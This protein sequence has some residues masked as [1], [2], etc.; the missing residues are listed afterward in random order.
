MTS[1][2][3]YI[4]GCWCR[5]TIMINK[6][7]TIRKVFDKMVKKGLGTDYDHNEL[8]TTALDYHFDKGYYKVL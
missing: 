8:V 1:K 4:M 2:D 7:K 6:A 3:A 5:E